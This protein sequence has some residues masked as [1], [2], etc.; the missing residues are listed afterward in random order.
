MIIWGDEEFKIQQELTSERQT[1]HPICQQLLI[2][3]S[4]GHYITFRYTLEQSWG[5]KRIQFYQVANINMVSVVTKGHTKVV[6]PERQ[7]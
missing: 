6:K 5:G 4:K 1:Q 7:V 2:I 3:R